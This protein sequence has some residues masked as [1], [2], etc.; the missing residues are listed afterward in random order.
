MDNTVRI[1]QQSS[2]LLTEF[3]THVVGLFSEETLLKWFPY[4]AAFHHSG[5]KLIEMQQL[6]TF[7]Q[8]RTV[9]PN[10]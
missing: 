5:V 1:P 3:A 8:R 7:D 4:N 9:R 6:I 2:F 10:M